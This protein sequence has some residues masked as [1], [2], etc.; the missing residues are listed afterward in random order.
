[1]ISAFGLLNIASSDRMATKLL[2]LVSDRKKQVKEENSS[3]GK[4]RGRD[5]EMEETL[6][7]LQDKVRELERH[8][9]MLK[10]KVRH[11]QDS[12]RWRERTKRWG[13]G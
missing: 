4:G 7:E 5:L 9:D 6:E 3:P 10:N 11:V 13:G 8:N 2:R 1:M 12:T